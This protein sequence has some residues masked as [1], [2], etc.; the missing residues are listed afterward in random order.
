MN[1]ILKVEIK[2]FAP[3]WRKNTSQRIKLRFLVTRPLLKSFIYVVE[4]VLLNEKYVY[5]KYLFPC[6]YKF[7]NMYYPV[8]LLYSQN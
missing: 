4:T 1:K 6:I 5:K 2:Y 3:H 7:D 8:F